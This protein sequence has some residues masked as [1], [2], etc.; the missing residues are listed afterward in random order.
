MCSS[1]VIGEWDEIDFMSFGFGH[2]FALD[3]CFGVLEVLGTWFF[4]C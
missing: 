3:D 4:F 1:G 2:L